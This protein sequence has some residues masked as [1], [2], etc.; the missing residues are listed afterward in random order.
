MFL[1]ALYG[2]LRTI[3]GGQQVFRETA[4]PDGEGSWSMEVPLGRSQMLRKKY[5]F[6]EAFVAQKL[7]YIDRM[8]RKKDHGLSFVF[9][10]LG[11]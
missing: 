6:S 9:L 2:Y 8:G 4:C 5:E 7:Q 10:D 1:S 11:G 3:D